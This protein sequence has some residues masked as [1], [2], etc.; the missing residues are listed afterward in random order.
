MEID[1][2]QNI[3]IK[4]CLG[5]EPL[6][7]G[8]EECFFKHHLY[9]DRV[10]L[11]EKY[12]EGVSI[13]QKNG[14]K[15]EKDYIDFYVD[16]GWWSQ[17]KEDEIR[18]IS[19]FLEN[20]RKSKE[21]MI[22]PSQR[23]QIAK[24]IVEEENKLWSIISE[25]KSI[26]PMT[27]EQYADKYYNKFYLHNSLYRDTEFKTRF[28]S[29][30]QYF[31]ENLD[32]DSYDSIWGQIL[33]LIDLLKIENIKYVAAS[34]FFQNLLVLIGKEMSIFDF[35][36][37]PVT[38]LTINQSDL[39]YYGSSYR[40]SINNATEVIP[41]Y[42]L[43]DPLNL[44]DWCEGGHSSSGKVKSMMDKTPNKNKTKGERSGR[45][46]SIVGASSSDYKKLGIG[47]VASG[48]SDLLSAAE[49]SGGEMP[50]NQIIKKTDKL[51]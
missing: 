33:N 10:I 42:I 29:S 26:I 7:I 16:K 13:A 6:T 8:G 51:K 18:T 47:G 46:S 14:I 4:I 45:I 25:K 22:V 49:E 19:A 41:E 36:G 17:K 35:Y 30:E 23:E 2:I 5:Y 39:F 50:I 37:K 24:T 21:K 40:R 44:I 20:L 38:Q 43:S 31:I 48:G 9:R 15:T 28:A 27:A 32:D 3:Y 11:K 34:G 1:D 12:R